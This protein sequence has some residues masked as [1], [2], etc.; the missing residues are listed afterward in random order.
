M[1]HFNKLIVGFG[2]ITMALMS[3]CGRSAEKLA[4]ALEGSWRGA[5]EQIDVDSLYI[6]YIPTYTFQYGDEAS[7]SLQ[8]MTLMSVET[9]AKSEIDSLVTISITAAPTATISGSYKVDDDKTI[10]L[11]FSRKSFKLL[12]DNPSVRLTYNTL[13]PEDS[14]YLM[15]RDSIASRLS[16]KLRE[17]MIDRICADDEFRSVE[18]SNNVME[19]TPSSC[20]ERLT[21]SRLP[22]E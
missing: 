8:L 22:K 9:F 6:D 3:G 21:L 1:M 12:L 16:E 13:V 2:V 4:E 18:I 10:H 17:L 19:V 20:S 7:G 5:P 14:V 15:E 11:D